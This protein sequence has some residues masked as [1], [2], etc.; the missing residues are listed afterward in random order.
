MSPSMRGRAEVLR[1]RHLELFARGILH[2]PTSSSPGS[3]TFYV[4]VRLLLLSC[5]CTLDTGRLIRIHQR[6]LGRAVAA[7][8]GLSDLGRFGVIIHRRLVWARPLSGEESSE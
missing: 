4:P 6:R 7:A 5:T 8:R 3:L 2:S 1:C